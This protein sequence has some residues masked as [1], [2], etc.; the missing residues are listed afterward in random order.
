M[1]DWYRKLIQLRRTTPSLNNGEPGNTKVTYNEEQRWLRVARGSIEIAC[2]L[3][4]TASE[5]GLPAK[6][7]AKLLLA[8]RPGRR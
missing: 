8:S 5:S 6:R 3:A 4:P 2:N 7:G 1:L